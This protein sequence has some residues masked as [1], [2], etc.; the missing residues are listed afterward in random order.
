WHGESIAVKIV[1][2]VPPAG[3]D[4]PEDLVRVER[5]LNAGRQT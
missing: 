3:V 2:A 1:D 5:L 4:T